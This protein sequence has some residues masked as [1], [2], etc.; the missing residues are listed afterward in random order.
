MTKPR[1]RLADTA[2]VAFHFGVSPGTIRRWAHEHRWHPYGTRRH[3]LWSLDEAQRTRDEQK[4]RRA[5][6]DVAKRRSANVSSD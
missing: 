5:E 4:R 3:R 1:L 2:A 6:R